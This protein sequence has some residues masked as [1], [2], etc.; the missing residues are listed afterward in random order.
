MAQ[1]TKTDVFTLRFS[2]DGSPWCRATAKDSIDVSGL[3]FSLDGSPWGTASISSA[4]TFK[5]YLG[6][7][8]ITKIYLASSPIATFHIGSP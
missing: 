4:A 7:T 5:M 3:N 1:P 6:S 2:K 8:R